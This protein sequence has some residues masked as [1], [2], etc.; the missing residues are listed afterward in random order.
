MKR[1]AEI[2]RDCTSLFVDASICL[3]APLQTVIDR[4][5][6]HLIC[7]ELGDRRSAWRDQRVVR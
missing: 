5:V 7:M 2:L 6:P 3:V 1:H 4:E